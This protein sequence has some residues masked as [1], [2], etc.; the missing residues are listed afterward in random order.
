MRRVDVQVEARQGTGSSAARKT[1]AA[2]RLP[3]V[4]YGE[5]RDAAGYTVDRHFFQHLVGSDSGR[6]A[7]LNLQE[8]GGE[9]LSIIKDLQ[10]HPL[11][12]AVI[13]ADLQRISM[14]HKVTTSV[15]IH[16]EG[17]PT[18]VRNGGGILETL[19]REIEIECLPG[20]IPDNFTV[21]VTYMEIGDSLHVGALTV[22]EKITVLANPDTVL[23]AVVSPTLE[24]EA[25]PGEEEEGATEPEAMHGETSESTE[26]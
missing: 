2:G 22:D 4:V 5:K 26:S 19:T 8:N 20:D 9:M 1:R 14:D 10:Y 18:G 13:H 21:D 3:V 12:G 24:R 15:V 11:T 23:A 17:I 6:H 7:I 16:L 25:E